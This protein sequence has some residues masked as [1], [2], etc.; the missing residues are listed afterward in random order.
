MYNQVLFVATNGQDIKYLAHSQLLKFISVSDHHIEDFVRN[1]VSVQRTCALIA[2]IQRGDRPP[3]R[4]ECKPFENQEEYE[5]IRRMSRLKKVTGVNFSEIS[6]V[7][8]RVAEMKSFIEQSMEPADEGYANSKQDRN[9]NDCRTKR[10]TE[11]SDNGRRIDKQRKT[12]GALYHD[13]QTKKDMK[14]GL[15]RT[16]SGAF[17]VDTVCLWKS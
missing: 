15:R 2:S 13:S 7:A 17:R 4:V 8:A 16:N 3:Y 11:N 9:D 12:G 5:Q 10:R 14:K 6:S 1:R